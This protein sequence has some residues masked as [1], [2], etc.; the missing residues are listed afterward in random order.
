[1][2]VKSIKCPE[3]GSNN[4]TEISTNTFVC[5]HCFTKYNISEYD[6]TVLH[7][8][9]YDEAHS[10]FIF[11]NKWGFTI[12]G[13]T[14]LGIITILFLLFSEYSNQEPQYRRVP[15]IPPSFVE[16]P[17]NAWPKPNQSVTPAKT[18]APIKDQCLLPESMLSQDFLLY[19]GGDYKG[20][21]LDFVIDTSG[22]EATQIDLYINETTKP[23]ALILGAYE[24]TIWQIHY[25]IDTRI[26]A[27]YFTGYNKQVLSGLPSNIPVINSQET[28]NCPS[29]SYIAEKNSPQVNQIAWK[30]FQKES[31]DMIY[32]AKNGILKMD[33]EAMQINDNNFR[34]NDP[35]PSESFRL[36][37]T[38]LAGKKGLEDAV[39]KGLIRY[40]TSQDLKNI[41]AAPHYS[42]LGNAYVILKPFTIPSG[43]YGA[44]SALFILDKD[45]PQPKGNLGHSSVYD[46]NTGGCRGVGCYDGS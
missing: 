36:E 13:L 17:V 21:Q 35:M 40:A 7:K 23:V 1:M 24:P 38:P 9:T 3:C 29:V 18:I 26:I 37:N 16:Q 42:M 32:L 31:V 19:A 41:K 46:T 30:A 27:V 43:L 4:K 25:S 28:N 22:H 45:V 34:Q 14:F 11:R 44:H 12:I 5:K 20:K 33:N 39:E 8:H 6:K 2:N 10:R 15:T